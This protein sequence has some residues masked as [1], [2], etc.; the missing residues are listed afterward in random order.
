MT[1]LQQAVHESEVRIA[2]DLERALR[3]C[4]NDYQR[5]Q[6]IRAYGFMARAHQDR[7]GQ[8]FGLPPMLHR[9]P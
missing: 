1:P 7:I 2:R 3:R 9:A 5:E 8:A 4:R 6:C